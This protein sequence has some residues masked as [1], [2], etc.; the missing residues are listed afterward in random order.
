MPRRGVTARQ[1][2][3]YVPMTTRLRPDAEVPAAIN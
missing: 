2:G 1:Y 3:S